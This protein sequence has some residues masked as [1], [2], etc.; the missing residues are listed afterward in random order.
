MKDKRVYLL[1]VGLKH[2]GFYTGILDG[3]EGPMT[4]GAIAAWE[5]TLD[6]TAA[7]SSEIP[8]RIVEIAAS[9]IGIREVTKNQG[10][11]IEKYWA[12]T[13]YPDGH[14]NRE[15]YCAAFV[16]WVVREADGDKKVPFSLPKSPVA[17]DIEKWAVANAKKGVTT[18]ARTSAPKPGDIFTLTAASHV[19][20]I[21]SV[22]KSMVTTLEGNTDGS[23]SR[24]GDGVYERTRTIASL[25]K[26]VRITA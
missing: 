15:P 16:C 14:T 12:A 13:T 1:Q 2:L 18:V 20:I 10:P 11:G 3:D 24:E 17:Y 26:V 4:R 19:G 8:A 23:G 7:T 25:R 9:Q 6:G 5:A 21:K 22:G